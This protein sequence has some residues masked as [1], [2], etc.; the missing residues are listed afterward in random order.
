VNGRRSHSK[1]SGNNGNAIGDFA[2]A[3]PDIGHATTDI[4]NAIATRPISIA[5]YANARAHKRID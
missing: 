5:P 4:G 1:Y 2:I 3:K